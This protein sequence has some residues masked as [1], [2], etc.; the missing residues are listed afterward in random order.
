MDN[1]L[2]TNNKRKLN[3][4]LK[5]N[6]TN[7]TLNN[8]RNNMRNNMK[9]NKSKKK[10]SKALSYILIFIIIIFCPIALIVY[11]IYL[12]MKEQNK[13]FR[14]FPGDDDSDKISRT[15][16][17]GTIISCLICASSLIQATLKG[18]G[19]S[20]T[21]LL[22]LYGFITANVIGF[23][24]DQGFGTDNGFS[25]FRI[26]KSIND[27]KIEGF[28]SSLKYV[29]GTLASGSFWRFVITVFLDMFI[30]A[31]LQ[32]IIVAV[33]NPKLQIL[34]NTISI[35]PKF[36]GGLLGFVVKNFDNVLQS[37]VAF[38]TFL[39]YANDVR[40]MW[41]YPGDDINPDLLISSGTIKLA[42]AIA[43]IVYLVANVSADYNIIEGVKM[44][45]GASLVDSL[46]R[47][48]I[49][50]IILIGLLTIGSFNDNSFMNYR[51]QLYKIKP[52]ND[53]KKP[54][55]W[56]YN[57]KLNNAVDDKFNIVKDAEGNIIK[58][59]KYPR[60]GIYETCIVDDNGQ[61]TINYDNID[62]GKVNINQ[63]D[64]K[65][66][67]IDGTIINESN[68]ETIKDLYEKVS[69]SWDINR[70][71][72]VPDE[73]YI[74]NKKVIEDNGNTPSNF[75]VTNNKYNT[76]SLCKKEKKKDKFI[77]TNQEID[78][79][80]TNYH[81]HSGNLAKRVDMGIFKLYAKETKYDIMNKSK[82][83]FLIFCLYLFIGVCLPFLP[84]SYIYNKNEM[85][86]ASWFK[87]L[88]IV[89]VMAGLAIALYIV[90]LKSP[91]NNILKK[92]EFEKINQTND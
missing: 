21:M 78:E 8:M 40:F 33:L 53:Y 81:I 5:N 35:M 43:G 24:G 17:R 1:K 64:F 10:T 28:G 37:F 25:L 48:M 41:A 80:L 23:M 58:R 32:S 83:G 16:H 6:A 42:V 20:S 49:F 67:K 76:N 66:D 69:K 3:S 84:V 50:V 85:N 31:P 54:D 12:W 9:N 22:L 47:K 57:Q 38:I 61:L 51:Q 87:F 18:F 13:N 4:I 56:H 30:S 59:N 62:N 11:T 68:Q 73:T 72:I 14:W 89:S 74:C 65:P 45:T 52:I 90:V 77:N 75:G 88:I 29:F 86:K 60:T 44:K 79:R 15:K 26:G 71:C 2:N 27:K 34:N 7:S 82:K 92:K 46:P 70:P 55:F 63:S 39:A 19:A 36:F 91:S